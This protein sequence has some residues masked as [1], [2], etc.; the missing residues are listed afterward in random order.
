MPRGY[1]NTEADKH[2]VLKQLSVGKSYSRVAADTGMP[3]GTVAT[4]AGIAMVQGKLKPRPRGRP[5]LK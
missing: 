4:I 3:E 5:K 1:P 2:A